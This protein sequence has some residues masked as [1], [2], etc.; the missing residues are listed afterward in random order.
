MKYKI[1]SFVKSLISFVFL[2]TFITTGHAAGLGDTS[3]RGNS[4]EASFQTRYIDSVDIDFEG[5]AKAS[6]NDNLGWAIGIGYNFDKNWAVNFDIG[7]SEVGYSGTRIDDNSNPQTVSGTLNTSSFNINSIYHFSP[8]RFTP[9]IGASVGMTFIDTNI[10]NGDSQTVCWYDP[11][12][13][14]ICES[15]N[16]T[17][18]TSEFNYGAVVGLRFEVTNNLFFSGSYGKQWIDFSNAASTTNLDIY[19][20]SVGFMF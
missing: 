15:Y 14:Y 11:W 20:F 6:L 13:G 17:K 18:T 19:R 4:W 16:P 8:K 3:K 9:F 7:W 2:F 10:P 1:N 12:W 5:G